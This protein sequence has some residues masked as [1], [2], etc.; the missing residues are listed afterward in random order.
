MEGKFFPRN[1]TAKADYI[2]RGNP[3][4]SRPESG[5]DN[6]FP[7]LEF[8]QRN[9]EK[10]FFPGLY[11]EFHL[12]EGAI[13]K[14]VQSQGISVQNDILTVEDLNHEKKFYLW[15][16]N[17]VIPQ[18][19][20]N[21]NNLFF[22]GL[23][24]LEVWKR[25]HML[26]PGTLVILIGSTPGYSS[27]VSE[28]LE[29][30]I[31][32]NY[33]SKKGEIMRNN[34]GQIEWAI[35]VGERVTYLDNEGVIDINT[36]SPGEITRTLCV[37]WQYDFRDCGCFYWASNKPDIVSSSDKGQPY[38]NFV[39]KDRTS[40]PPPTDIP[41]MG[42]PEYPLERRKQEIDYAQTIEGAWN[43]VLPV[44]LNNQESSTFT[45]EIIPSGNIMTVQEVMDELY[46]LAE[47][48]HALCVEY[49]YAHYSLKA[50]I[51]L[52]PDASEETKLIF[53]AANE[54]FRVAVDEM[55]HLHWVNEA[56]DLL[57]Q[58]PNVGRAKFIGREQERPFTL[59]PLTP[60]QLQWF[61]D[62]EAPSKSIDDGVDGMYV[63]ILRSITETPDFPKREQLI[64]LIQ[65]IIDE[66]EGHYERFLSVQE[67]LK[68]MSPADYLRP[69]KDPEPNTVEHVMQTL[70]D[71]NYRVLLGTLLLSF[72]MGDKA[73]GNLIKQARHAM[74]ALHEIS[75]VLASKGFRTPFTM[76]EKDML[77]LPR[78]TNKNTKIAHRYVEDIEKSL[79]QTSLN[80]LE[81]VDENDRDILV[82]QQRNMSRLFQLMHH[83][84]EVN[85]TNTEDT[86]S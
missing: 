65:L 64:P 51:E 36:Y 34:E 83:F 19:S 18:T 52:T 25:I 29:S 20:S 7:G 53:A 39:R 14:T 2:V 48:E 75:H 71:D 80:L 35:L 82:N 43:H 72:S 22:R 16:L 28:E 33:E 66:G 59:N 86:S 45:Q 56:L 1:L 67:K 15:A 27:E 3:V 57:Q 47:V 31:L 74:F 38:L 46:Y 8:D 55:R 85:A 49:L 21:R 62:V 76:P 68:N 70:C 84:V 44:V 30:R 5:V 12:D 32:S 11:F 13:L 37:P 26:A 50:P 63:H 41:R 42:S 79:N 17:G 9:L 81:I 77:S 54:I 73:G 23:S 6:C 61:I 4:S 60:E 24:G 10:Q 40:N 78:L 69:M 58:S